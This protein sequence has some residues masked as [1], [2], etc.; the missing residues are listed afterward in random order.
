V[1]RAFAR[2]GA[3]VFLAGRTLAKVEAVAKEIAEAGGVAEAAQEGDLPD[4]LRSSL[5]VLVP[6]RYG[7]LLPYSEVPPPAYPGE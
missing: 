4:T 2:E 5:C 6:R 3:R 7:S 1:A